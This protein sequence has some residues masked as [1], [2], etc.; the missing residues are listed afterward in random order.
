MMGITRERAKYLFQESCLFLALSYLVLLGGTFNGLVLYSLNVI[1]MILVSGIGFLWILI[2]TIRKSDFP[3]T[4]LDIGIFLFLLTS[5]L[6]TVFSVDPRRSLISFIIL[7]VTVLVYYLFTDLIRRGL[8]VQLVSKVM[9]LV[10]GFILFFGVWELARWYS[11]WFSISGIGNLIPPA[12]YRVRAF[13]G[14]P[15]IAA[16]YLNLLIPLGL[17]MIFRTKKLI[18]KLLLGLWV[19]VALLLVYF[20]SS[21]AGWL[22]TFSATGTFILFWG[23]A[24]WE[25]SKRFLKEMIKK[26]WVIV[27]IT[28]IVV[29]GAATLFALLRWQS[30]HPSHPSDWSNIF[31]SRDYIWIVAWDMITAK[32]IIGNGLF[33]FGSEYFKVESIPPNMLLTHA[34]NYY[35]NVTAEMGIVGFV[36]LLIGFGSLIIMA[37]KAWI[38]HDNLNR[39]ELAGIF[40]ALA[41][42]SAHSLF[43]TPQMMPLL[44]ILPAI[45]LAQVSSGIRI[46][47][48]A[49]KNR[50]GN[51]SIAGLW[52][53]A[54][55]GLGLDV[56][57]LIPFNKG[58]EASNQENWTEAAAYFDQAVKLD[59]EN[60]FYWLQE[61]FSYGKKALNA[62]G[63]VVDENSL[64][65]A[66]VAYQKGMEIEPDYSANWM[67]LGLLQWAKGERSK[68]IESVKLA[69]EKSPRQG[70]FF[71]T[72]GSM[73]ENTGESKGAKEAYNQAL[74]QNS[75]WVDEPF[76]RENSFR[77]GVAS[78]WRKGIQM[79]EI[80]KN[81]Y[82]NEGWDL[83]DAEKYELALIAFSQAPSFNNPETHLALG[84][85][86]LM[87]KELPAAERN[88]RTALWMGSRDEWLM[89][90]INLSLGDLAVLKKDCQGAIE[91]YSRAVE[92]LERTTSYGIGKMGTSQ[93]GW[94][95]FYKPSIALDLLP[96][97]EN[98]IF[99]TKAIEGMHNLGTCYLELG[100]AKLAKAVYSDILFYRPDDI[101][102]AQKY[103]EIYD[104]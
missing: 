89:T 76:F 94:Y 71:L 80:E 77:E 88:L 22:G 95:L 93:Y 79:P 67:N 16:A 91:Y 40:G 92:L 4:G 10:S 11:G 12:T 23:M 33:T 31:G 2:R 55:L 39:I 103:A 75:Y 44:M 59:S 56:R 96:G 3:R 63:E 46:D 53:I 42:L 6:S 20:T 30:S 78:E 81:T 17:A 51:L 7:A 13:L 102:A 90:K 48:S 60:A 100:Q 8:P 25:K 41:G 15:N 14:H 32:P 64:N 43:E 98:I 9:I 52:L 83:L 101:V 28:S 26:K 97:M 27:G 37:R 54:S 87:L 74:A 84:K 66:I 21:R 70:A 72:L 85:T 47:V 86:Y 50:I 19:F 82:L 35:L 65:Q 45:L 36:A 5:V 24:N 58:I 73:L 34:H 61:G 57:A 18:P 38:S 49:S 69:V 99:S 68:A 29:L 1:N 104:E 62:K